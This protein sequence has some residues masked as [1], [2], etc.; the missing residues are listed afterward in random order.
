MILS[1]EGE[2][3]H[4]DKSLALWRLEDKTIQPERS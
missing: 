3:R 2:G 1:R 4:Q